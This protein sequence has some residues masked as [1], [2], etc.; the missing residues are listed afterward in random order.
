MV[1]IGGSSRS[2]ANPPVET[3]NEFRLQHAIGINDT[4]N[5]ILLP[6]DDDSDTVSIV[7]SVGQQVSTINVA[8]GSMHCLKNLSNAKITCLI[9]SPNKS[10]IAICTRVGDENQ[11]TITTPTGKD[12]KIFRSESVGPITTASFSAD[13][14][15]IVLASSNFVEVWQWE[16]DALRVSGSVPD[17]RH[18]V[19][20]QCSPLLLLESGMP[21]ITTSGKSHMRIWSASSKDRISNKTIM[22][23]PKEEQSN[24]FIDHI[25]VSGQSGDGTWR[26]AA[27]ASSETGEQTILVFSFSGAEN[28]S[29]PTVRTPVFIPLAVIEPGTII[30]CISTFA[31]GFVVAGSHGF[32]GLFQR[33]CSTFSQIGSACMSSDDEF[34]C[35]SSHSEKALF[36]SKNKRFHMCSWQSALKN[37]NLGDIHE[38]VVGGFH[39]G[40]IIAAAF[41][42][43]RP[44]MIT[45]GSD[46]CVRAWL[47]HRIELTIFYFTMHI[48][49]SHQQPFWLLFRDL[50]TNK[51]IAMV[52]FPEVPRDVSFHPGGLQVS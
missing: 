22:T 2:S 39:G 5:V 45:A 49:D 52:Q 7:A 46:K 50:I 47:V 31:D 51:C 33:D 28:S 19:R 25:W 4:S 16:K 26:L 9:L 43:A 3:P 6:N 35:I 36:A 8:D 14:K 42:K 18:I 48:F 30:H 1:I 12:A 40:S 32:I 38:V 15:Q 27:V 24:N 17:G 11:I 13:S 44:F 34:K 10:Y 21:L 37:G 20:I 23:I 41:A 29:S